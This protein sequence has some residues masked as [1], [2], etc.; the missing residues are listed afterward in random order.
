MLFLVEVLKLFIVLPDLLKVR[1]DSIIKT[2][3]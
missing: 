3:N 2:Q 1:Q